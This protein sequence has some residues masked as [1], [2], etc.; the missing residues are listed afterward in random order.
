MAV[1]TPRI[2]EVFIRDLS[3]P[4]TRGFSTDFLSTLS[5]A[6]VRCGKSWIKF[7][8]RSWIGSMGRSAE[9]IT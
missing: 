2:R 5:E 3:R 9:K 4:A 7:A 8:M 6:I 1:K